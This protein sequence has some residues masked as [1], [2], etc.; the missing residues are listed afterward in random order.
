MVG[1]IQSYMSVSGEYAYKMKYDSEF[2]RY[3][4]LTLIFTVVVEVLGYAPNEAVFTDLF[5]ADVYQVIVN[6]LNLQKSEMQ[7]M[8]WLYTDKVGKV[9]PD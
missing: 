6:F 8:S 7:D 9:L 4:M 2:A 1:T 5:G 3:D